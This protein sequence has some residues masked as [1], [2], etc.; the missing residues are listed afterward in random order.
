MASENQPFPARYPGVMVSST[1]Q[2]LKEHRAVLIS[3]L[4]KH[5]LFT[6]G[7]EDHVPH[8]NDDVLSSSL[9]MVR[10]GSAYIGLISHRYGQIPNHANLNPHLIRVNNLIA[11]I[12]KQKLWM[13]SVSEFIPFGL[14]C[15]WENLKRFII[16]IMKN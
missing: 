9:Q 16:F 7:M 11:P 5:E 12:E 2:D 10:D 6:I 14:Y 3:T 13:M 8:P 1:F 4:K 15:T